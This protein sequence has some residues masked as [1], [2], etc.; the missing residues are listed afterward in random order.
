MLLLQIPS[1]M[2]STYLLTRPELPHYH[3][4]QATPVTEEKAVTSDF[5]ECYGGQFQVLWQPQNPRVF[6]L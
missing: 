5:A 4:M 2:A 1:E 3:L 6:A